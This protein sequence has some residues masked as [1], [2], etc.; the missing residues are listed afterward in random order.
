MASLKMPAS[1]AEVFALLARA[2]FI[3][4][5]LITL[6]TALDQDWERLFACGVAVSPT[7]RATSIASRGPPP[8]QPARGQVSKGRWLAWITQSRWVFTNTSVDFVC[9][10]TLKR[11]DGRFS[12]PCFT[13]AGGLST[14]VLHRKFIAL[15]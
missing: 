1:D 2:G 3:A 11:A 5:R 10:H 14:S 4:P 8:S 9:V 12:I 15:M 6:G 7:K 13:P